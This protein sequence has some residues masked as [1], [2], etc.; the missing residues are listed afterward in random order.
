MVRYIDQE[1]TMAAAVTDE[2][3]KTY[4]DRGDTVDIPLHYDIYVPNEASPAFARPVILFL[5][6]GAFQRPGAQSIGMSKDQADYTH[7]A[8]GVYQWFVTRGWAVMTM[9]YRTTNPIG[10]PNFQEHTAVQDIFHALFHAQQ[11]AHFDI[12]SIDPS[13]V[14]VMGES[15]GATSAIYACYSRLAHTKTARPREIKTNDPTGRY[16]GGITAEWTGKFIACVP[17]WAYDIPRFHP[18]GDAPAYC[19]AHATNDGIHSDE[20]ATRQV[21][22]MQKWIAQIPGER[23]DRVNHISFTASQAGGGPGH[24]L[25]SWLEMVFYGTWGN[26]LNQWFVNNLDLPGE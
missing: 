20:W 1:F 22:E 9:N 25:P 12:H 24:G 14:V 19:T 16:S 10:S 4:R 6:G 15:A 21:A 8:L 3:Y 23:A 17:C 11:A 7:A 13:K 18:S 26:T 5:H 2:V